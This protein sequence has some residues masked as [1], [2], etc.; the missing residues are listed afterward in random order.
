MGPNI[1]IGVRKVFDMKRFRGKEHPIL[2]E[3]THSIGKLAHFHIQS[4]LLRK[5]YAYIFTYTYRRIGFF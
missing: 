2:R 1:G 3:I 5:I 4:F